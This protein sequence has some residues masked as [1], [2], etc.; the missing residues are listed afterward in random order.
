MRDLACIVTGLKGMKTDQQEMEQGLLRG[1]E[2]SGAREKAF[3]GLC[4]GNMV[5]RDALVDKKK[6]NWKYSQAEGMDCSSSSGKRMVY[7]S[8]HLSSS[9]VSAC[10]FFR[11]R[12]RFSWSFVNPSTSVRFSDISQDGFCCKWE[13]R[14]SSDLKTPQHR[15]HCIG[16]ACR[17]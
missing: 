17:R 7:I 5:Q 3:H 13:R 1:E 14:S 2:V 8:L 11:L 12:R 6:G 4:A 15:G 9:V 10:A 16:R